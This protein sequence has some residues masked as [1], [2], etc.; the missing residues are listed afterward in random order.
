MKK[1]ILILG[2][3][4]CGKTLLAKQV[5]S[6]FDESKVSWVGG[7]LVPTAAVFNR[8][9]VELC[10]EIT[11]LVIIDDVNRYTQLYEFL[12]GIPDYGFSMSNK[13]KQSSPTINPNFIFT[14]SVIRKTN[15]KRGM[16]KHHFIIVD[17]N[18][19]NVESAFIDICG[20]LQLEPKF[21]SLNPLM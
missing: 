9:M 19:Q 5:A 13:D 18:K 3:S 6:Q 2:K 1:A 11:E 4:G 8:F 14:S 16:N 17:L 10:S 15:V 20:I 7:F 21:P 12:N